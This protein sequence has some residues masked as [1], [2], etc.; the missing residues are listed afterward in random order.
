MDQARHVDHAI[1]SLDHGR[2][3]SSGAHCCCLANLSCASKLSATLLFVTFALS[4]LNLTSTQADERKPGE[5]FK[6]CATNCPE[7]V[8]IPSGSF[9]MGSTIYEL[10]YRPSE[11]PQHKI[12]IAEPFAVSKFEVTFAEW[13]TCAADGDCAARVSD[14]GWGRDRQPIINVGWDDAQRYVTWLSKITGK[15]YRLLTEAEYEYAARAGTRTAYPWGDEVG[16]NNANCA[17]CGSRWDL[18][19]PAPVG[20]FRP[21]Q[22]GLYD[23]VGNVWEW[24]EDCLHEDYNGAPPDDGSAWMTGG[25][26]SKR[27]LRGGSWASVP[28]EVRSANRSRGRNDDRSNIIG[29]R[30]GRSLSP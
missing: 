8:V 29:F 23:M 15:R 28:D 21:N 30:V 27:R 16:R 19:Q 12:T 11:G 9:A 7:M 5:S 17:G 14:E 2:G 24:V 18:T 22:F 6:D 3:G 4:Q 20:S 1:E 13:D 25:D 10:A 26:C